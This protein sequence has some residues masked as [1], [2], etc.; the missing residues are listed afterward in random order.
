[1]HVADDITGPKKKA[2]DEGVLSDSAERFAHILIA[3]LPERR[4]W[5]RRA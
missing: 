3:A 2:A 5:R 1:M 4:H